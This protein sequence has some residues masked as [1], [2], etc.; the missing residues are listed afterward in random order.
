MALILGDTRRLIR[1]V[2]DESIDLI[3]TDPPYRT[4]SGGTSTEGRPVGILIEN[5]GRIFENNDVEFDEYMPDLFR[6]LTDPGHMYMMV[7]FLNLERAMRSIR[8][9][10]FDIHGI[11]TWHKNNATPN[12]WWMKN[13]EH[14]IFARKGVARTIYTPGAMAC[15]SIPNLLGGGRS[16]PTEKPVELME[17]L[18]LAS[19]LP[20][21]LVMDPFMGSGSTGV[22]AMRLGRKFIGM[23]IDD[24]YYTRAVTRIG[25]DARAVHH[26]VT[27]RAAGRVEAAQGA[28]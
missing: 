10:G 21:E 22:A 14:I 11:L 20:G 3:V 9:A 28:D 12:R 24:E 27:T 17:R 25:Q 16:H 23:E 1:S 18:I 15:M 8:W 2:P 5:D 4:I 26:M 7:N 19:S 13:Q 6:V